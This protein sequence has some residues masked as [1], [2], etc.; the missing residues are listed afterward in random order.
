MKS[1]LV[2]A[3]VVPAVSTE[4][5]LWQADSL[6]QIIQTLELERGELQVATHNIHHLLV[7]LAVGV[8]ILHKCC[9]GD[10]VGALHI[11]NYAT[12]VEVVGAS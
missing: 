11:T 3:A 9:I 2:V 8:G 12:C 4:R 10:V 7:L 6:H 1:L 5:L